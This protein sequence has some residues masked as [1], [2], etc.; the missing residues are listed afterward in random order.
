MLSILNNFN[1][2][3]FHKGNPNNQEK[4]EHS[5]K[6]ANESIDSDFDTYHLFYYSQLLSCNVYLREVYEPAPL[7]K[8]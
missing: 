2:L 5:N 4:L 8:S 6:V 7:Q 3:L 1:V